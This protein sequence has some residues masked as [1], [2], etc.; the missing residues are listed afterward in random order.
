MALIILLAEKKNCFI[1]RFQ[2]LK[3]MFSLSYSE[4]TAILQQDCIP[5]AFLSASLPLKN[6]Q[7]ARIDLMHL[8]GT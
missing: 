5:H 7:R 4:V 8:T 2:S 6:K 1:C 3:H